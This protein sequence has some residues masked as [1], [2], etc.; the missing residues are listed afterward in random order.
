MDG[1]SYKLEPV[2]DHC[3]FVTKTVRMTITDMKLKDKVFI[4]TGA[5][6][7]MGRGIALK[8]VEEGASLIVNG[9]DQKR[10]EAVVDEI[11][12]NGGTVEFLAGDVGDESNNQKLVQKAIEHFG[13]LDGVVTNAGFLGLGKIT[14]LETEKWH[15]TIQTNLDSVY[16]LLKYA[17]PE[18]QKNEK[19]VAVINSSIAAYK[20][21]PNHAAYCAS[22]AG[23]LALAKQAAV[24]YGPEIRINAICPGPVDTPLLHDSAIA[25]PDPEAAVPEAKKATLMKRLGQPK[26]IAQLALF[27]ASEDSSWIT[28]SAFTI[29]GGIMAN[30]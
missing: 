15:R 8:F 18:M 3:D 25:F 10:G 22:K 12:S 13:K 5:T 7:G 24:D 11:S 29:D 17:I 20:S 14:E 6:N 21:F 1:P 4:I 26:D 30:S 23:L 2:G 19:G 16:Y 28:G 27:L 9:R